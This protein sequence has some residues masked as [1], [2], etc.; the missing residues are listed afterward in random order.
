MLTILQLKELL[1]RSGFETDDSRMSSLNDIL[2]FLAL[3]SELFKSGKYAGINNIQNILR[4]RGVR[5]KDD[6]P[7]IMFLMLHNIVIQQNENDVIDACNA[8]LMAIQKSKSHDI[9]K[10]LL[11]A[12]GVSIFVNIAIF[13]FSGNLHLGAAY[14][15]GLLMT[16]VFSY[17]WFK[18]NNEHSSALNQYERVVS[19][20]TSSKNEIGWTKEK[21]RN[22]IKLE[23]GVHKESW[24]DAASKVL[25]HEINIETA[26]MET[27]M[28]P[29][30]L[31]DI[32]NR[33]AY[34]RST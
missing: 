1:S 28:S 18:K 7:A 9:D 32:I 24:V 3:N 12:L 31:T 34:R 14:I 2:Q 30:M 26:A 16:L 22:S 29:G 8:K 5:I 23:F 27:G 33:I 11:I 4:A 20:I 19:E 10:A 13:V 6:D 17:F 21:I 15:F 25:I